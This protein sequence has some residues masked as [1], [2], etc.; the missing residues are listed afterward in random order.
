MS[1]DNFKNLWYGC[2]K[3]R[4]LSIRNKTIITAIEKTKPD[5]IDNNYINLALKLK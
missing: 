5:R 2:V 3:T 4:S 1:F